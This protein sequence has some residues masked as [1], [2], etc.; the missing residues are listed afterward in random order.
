MSFWRPL[1]AR[2]SSRIPAIKVNLIGA[3]VGYLNFVVEQV[4]PERGAT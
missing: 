4:F 1:T 2:L 3:H